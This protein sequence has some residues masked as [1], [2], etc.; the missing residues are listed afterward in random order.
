VR[1]LTGFQRDLLLV[2]P[3]ESGQS[4]ATIKAELEDY[5]ENT[6]NDGRFYP[7]IDILID[8]GFVEKTV[9]DGRTNEYTLTRRGR[10]AIGSHREWENQ[11]VD[12]NGNIEL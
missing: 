8:E 5:Y 10:Q 1:D 9:V 12:G 7:N 6:I 3:W 2:I 4:G 11:F